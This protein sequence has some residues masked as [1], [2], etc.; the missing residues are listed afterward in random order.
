MEISISWQNTCRRPVLYNIVYIILFHLSVSI[1]L[2]S[3][4]APHPPHLWLAVDHH[5][6]WWTC[7][8]CRVNE[9]FFSEKR[10]SLWIYSIQ[11]EKI[12]INLE[13][14]KS[15][16]ICCDYLLSALSHQ[17]FNITYTE[18][19]MQ[20]YTHTHTQSVIS[21]RVEDF[22]P[23]PGSFTE[24][25]K[26]FPGNDFKAGFEA[27][28]RDGQRWRVWRKQLTRR[29]WW[30]FFLSRWKTHHAQFEIR[31]CLAVALGPGWSLQFAVWRTLDWWLKWCILKKNKEVKS[32]LETKTV[33]RDFIKIIFLSNGDREAG[34]LTAMLKSLRLLFSLAGL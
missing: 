21:S 24:S 8:H 16:R 2:A 7:P 1:C 33:C 34:K 19:E 20:V 32:A 15:I 3:P 28:Q 13:L 11:R 29:S 31:R 30:G 12:K 5:T 23:A 18:Q 9:D 4:I 22:K 10:R 26:S 14:I 27:A 6:V 17:P 25:A